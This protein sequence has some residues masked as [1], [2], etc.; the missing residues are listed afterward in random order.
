MSLKRLLRRFILCTTKIIDRAA[1]RNDKL[2]AF[3]SPLVGEGIKGV[4]GCFNDKLRAFPSPLVGEGIKGVRGCI[5]SL[6][7]QAATDHSAPQH[8]IKL[9]HLT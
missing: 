3:P 5:N 2:R 1:P 7:I 4:R 9:G 8:D 6:S